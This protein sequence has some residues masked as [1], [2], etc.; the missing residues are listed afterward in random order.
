MEY[1]AVDAQTHQAPQPPTLMGGMR[2]GFGERMPLG[3][4]SPSF[5]H[6]SD[7]G[8]TM[9]QSFGEFRKDQLYAQ[10]LNILGG[11]LFDGSS[12]TGRT[13]SDTIGSVGQ[14]QGFRALTTKGFDAEPEVYPY[15]LEEIEQHGAG[16]SSIA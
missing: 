10:G 12:G 4:T 14:G 5:P 9:P 7:S 11:Y 16:P 6:S 13:V 3:P 2:R 15:Q 8:D 1:R